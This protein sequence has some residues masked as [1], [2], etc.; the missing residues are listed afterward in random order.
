MIQVEP[1]ASF[2]AVAKFP[3]GLAGTL[4]VRIID[5]VGGTT[6][7]R[8]TAGISE[9]PAGSGVYQVTLTA[10]G[11]AG[12][13]TLVW[14][15]A[16]GHYAPDDLLVTTTVTSAT[17]GSG[18][19]YVTR[20]ELKTILRLENESYDDDAIDIAVEAAS[21][22]CDGY[23]GKPTGFFASASE[24]RYYTADAYDTSIDI[25]DAISVSEVAV[26]TAGDGSY[27]TVW[28]E[29]TEFWLDPPNAV[30]DGQPRRRLV[31]TTTGSLITSTD[32]RDMLPPLVPTT[33]FPTYQ[34]AIRVTGT[35]GWPTVPAGVKA[36]T[37]LL[38]R[39]WLARTEQAPLGVLVAQS[40]EAVAMAALGAI[41]KDAAF[42]L[43]N[44]PG[45][46][47]RLFV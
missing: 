29:G 28:T 19:L 27:E 12:Q 31:L 42:Y 4:G 41:D 23:K 6:V 18:N 3:T 22:A 26:D 35:F 1:N 40:G 20:E 21:R 13:Y 24:V 14:D 39:R 16:D 36:A 47:R 43:D 25:D 2:E 37:I 8:A 7:A 46:T 38:A 45:A 30:T 11:S 44:I 9:Y 32:Q 34:R 5:N 15:D 33:R 10:P 17:I